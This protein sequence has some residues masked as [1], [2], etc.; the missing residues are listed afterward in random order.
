MV[1]FRFGIHRISSDMQLFYFV[2]IKL[3]NAFKKIKKKSFGATFRAKTKFFPFV[4]T[5]IKNMAFRA[6]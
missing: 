6:S 4:N 2:Q 5:Q 3:R 1:A